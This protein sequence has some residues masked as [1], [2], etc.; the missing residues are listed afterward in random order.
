M[1][2]LL[3]LMLP[4][5]LADF[6]AAGA[7][8]LW[9]ILLAG[10]LL[11]AF[12]SWLLGGPGSGRVHPVLVVYLLLVVLFSSGLT[13]RRIL[14]RQHLGTGDLLR[15]RT[16]QLTGAQREA[17]IAT[18]TDPG[19]VVLQTDPASVRLWVYTT[20]SLP[21]DRTWVTLESLLRDRMPSLEDLLIAG[22]P[23]PIGASSAVALIVGGLF[24]LY[25][26]LID[27]RVPL[28]IVIAA[29]LALLVL[30]IPVVITENEPVWRWMAFRDIDVGWQVAVTFVNYEILAGPLLFMAF[31]LATAP[32]VRP[33]TRRGRTF[34]AIA[35]GIL[36]A[37]FQLY[38]SVSYGPY[39]AL[40]VASLLSPVLDKLFTPRPLV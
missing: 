7:P 3:A 23:G 30:P 19:V 10:G 32:V 11:L 8:P 4:A 6:G 36:A 33:M 2:G 18:P 9:P 40:L 38:A 22:Q 16:E 21:P 27:Y 5:K 14:A 17:W 39:L 15:D 37:F 24:L 12:A 28:L 1:A 13:P 20:G 34:F 31:F 26:G 25:R 35:T 29:F